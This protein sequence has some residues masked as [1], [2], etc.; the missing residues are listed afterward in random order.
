M[1]NG[2]MAAS[3]VAIFAYDGWNPV[4]ETVMDHASGATN[5]IHYLW[6]LDLSDS[7]QGAGGVGGLRCLTLD[8]ATHIPCYDNNG[9][10]SEK[11]SRWN[12]MRILAHSNCPLSECVV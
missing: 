5:R 1:R 7:L 3:C 9:Y 11:P 2:L 6:G 10:S 4:L 12:C 8:G